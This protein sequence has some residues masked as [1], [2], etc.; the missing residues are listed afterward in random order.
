[1]TDQKRDEAKRYPPIQQDP[2]RRIRRIQRV[3]KWLRRDKILR[4]T[5][6]SQRLRNRRIRLLA[7]SLD[8]E[9][10]WLCS[11]ANALENRLVSIGPHSM[12]SELLISILQLIEKDNTI[13]EQKARI[14]ELE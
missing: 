3:Y 6:Q 14:G 12:A 13:A 11:Y 2:A 9:L 5:I 1:M 10:A 7:Q 4:R 8:A